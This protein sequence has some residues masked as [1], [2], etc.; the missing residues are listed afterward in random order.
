MGA[1]DKIFEKNVEL[2][3]P[4]VPEPIRAV[5]VF[6]RKGAFSS[7]AWGAAGARGVQLAEWEAGK[8]RAPDFPGRT[9]LA[10]TDTTL[11]AFEA[12]GGFSWKVKDQLGSWPLGTF[13]A[14]REDNK[15]HVVL[16]LDFGDGIRQELETMTSM[17]NAR[18][19][20]VVDLLCA[21]GLRPGSTRPSGRS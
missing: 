7:L 17:A 10:V 19:V 6:Q 2:V 11:H 3:Q 16:K 13:R 20:E 21:P 15:V 5:A 8:R 12:K 1:A 14:E 4:H 18:N 9:F